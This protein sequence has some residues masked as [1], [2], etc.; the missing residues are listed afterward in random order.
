MVFSSRLPGLLSR[1][2]TDE[3]ARERRFWRTEWR[4]MAAERMRP[5]DW[6]SAGAIRKQDGDAVENG[7]A[8]A[9]AGAAGGTVFEGQRLATDGADEEAE[10]VRAGVGLQGIGGHRSGTGY[11]D[12]R[13]G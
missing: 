13:G 12:R 4:G 6:D 8:A 5:D 1:S 3:T 11:Q 2:T 10:H 9:A 7:V